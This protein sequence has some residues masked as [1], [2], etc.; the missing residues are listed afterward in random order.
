MPEPLI[1]AEQIYFNR[2]GR[3]ILQNISLEINPATITTIIGP[4]G[5]G[6]SSLIK[7]LL[8]IETPT[9]GKIERRKDLKVGYMPQKL[10]VDETLPLK[11]HRLLSL[12][13]AVNRKQ[14]LWA[15]SR[16][17]VDY[18]VDQQVQKLSG[19]EFQRVMLARAILKRP[20]LLVL[21]E[22]VQGVD[23]TGEAEL[24]ELIGQI[25]DELNCA[26]LMVSHDLH[27]VMA[28]TDQVICINRHVCCQGSPDTISHHP[29]FMQLFNTHGDPNIAI[30]QH[31]HNHRHDLNEQGG[32]HD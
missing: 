19:G 24:Y 6:K 10:H 15:L 3:E 13:N 12:P 14:A 11:V 8:G 31:Q 23:F 16:T 5:A 18:L 1:S 28:K 17:G 30:Y 2:S 26:V 29:E 21:D 32:H 4:N 22:P 9:N 27:I 7:I 20:N 25:R